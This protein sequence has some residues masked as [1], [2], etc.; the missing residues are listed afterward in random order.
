MASEF[1]STFD[2]QGKRIPRRD[3]VSERGEQR[4]AQATRAK[5]PSVLSHIEPTTKTTWE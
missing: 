1:N 4:R 3:L 5:A 2:S